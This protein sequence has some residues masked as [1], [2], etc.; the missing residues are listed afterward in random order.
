MDY[1]HG[2]LNGMTTGNG[3]VG[4]LIVILVVI[5]LVLI[6]LKVLRK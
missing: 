2:W 4:T 5:A 3:R 6:I 1:I